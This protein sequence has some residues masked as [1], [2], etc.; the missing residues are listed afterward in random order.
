MWWEKERWS[1][2]LAM[3]IRN[4]LSMQLPSASVCARRRRAVSSF[5]GR[6]SS[7]RGWSGR[8]SPAGTMSWSS[9]WTGSSLRSPSPL[10]LLRRLLG[11]SVAVATTLLLSRLPLPA[12]R[13]LSTFSSVFYS[14]PSF[15]S[16]PSFSFCF[17][18]AFSFF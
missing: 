9:S 10:F 18:V 17:V 13:V 1:Q 2:P 14:W 5:N 16:F 15:S 11:D 6:K 12:F 7:T 4:P 8:V 3:P